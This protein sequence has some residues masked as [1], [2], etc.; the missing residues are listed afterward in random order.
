MYYSSIDNI[1]LH[2]YA[3]I[4]T[5]R[6]CKAGMSPA[7]QQTRR[8]TR[9][10]VIACRRSLKFLNLRGAWQIAQSGVLT[11]KS[12]ELST[13]N[14]R[15]YFYYFSQRARTLEGGNRWIGNALL[16]WQEEFVANTSQ[17]GCMNFATKKIHRLYQLRF[18]LWC[19]CLRDSLVLFL[20]GSSLFCEKTPNKV[21]SFNTLK[22]RGMHTN[23]AEGR[24]WCRCGSL[25]IYPRVTSLCSFVIFQVILVMAKI[26][27]S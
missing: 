9:A 19:F 15:I 10:R 14:L 20:C 5:I 12:T 24:V 26:L 8:A 13:N 27:M 6:G 11:H 22:K 17:K 21:S 25:E 2:M 4:Y 1:N 3:V 18:S 16:G 23:G 7:C